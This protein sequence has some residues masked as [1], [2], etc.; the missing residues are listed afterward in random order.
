MPLTDPDN[1]TNSARKKARPASGGS[2]RG[3]GARS[4]LRQINGVLA[5]HCTRPT[6]EGGSQPAAASDLLRAPATTDRMLAA[7][8]I[9][10]S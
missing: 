9:L 10:V 4:Q 8:D 6:F 2:I 1:E 3:T 5:K 7:V